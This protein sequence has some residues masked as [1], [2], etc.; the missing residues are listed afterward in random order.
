MRELEFS[1]SRTKTHSGGS[2]ED[3]IS[4]SSTVFASTDQVSCDLVGEVAILHVKSGIY[5]GL[6]TVGAH[7]WKLL[8]E[9]RAVVELLRSILETYD[10]DAEQAKTDL[11]ELLQNLADNELI[12]V[13]PGANGTA[14]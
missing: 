4:M 1:T 8:Q 10:V 2:L 5:Y 11:F 7:V 14:K 6:G 13:E 12:V 3:N 9:P